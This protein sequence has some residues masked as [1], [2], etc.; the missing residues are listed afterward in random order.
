MLTV[1]LV[2]ITA[3]ESWAHL[4]VGRVVAGL[5]VGNLSVGVPMFQSESSPRGMFQLQ[6]LP[7]KNE[8]IE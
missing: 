1:V 3:M 5:G 4:T 7:P 6:D 2:Q 8:G